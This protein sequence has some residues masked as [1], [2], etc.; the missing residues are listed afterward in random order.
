MEKMQV[1]S[2]TELVSLAEAGLAPTNPSCRRADRRL[3]IPTGQ[4]V[5]TPP[6]KL[7]PGGFCVERYLDRPADD[8]R[9]PAHK[10]FS[11]VLH[12]AGHAACHVKIVRPL[13]GLSDDVQQIAGVV[14]DLVNLRVD[15]TRVPILS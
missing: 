6:S 2:L 1:R 12:R 5:R 9:I 3:E 13:V 7:T 8:E 14:V 10:V 11:D 15:R 4:K